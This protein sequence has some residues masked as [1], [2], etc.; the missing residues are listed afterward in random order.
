MAQPCTRAVARTNGR[1]PIAEGTPD[2]RDLTPWLRGLGV[3]ASEARR[4]AEI[5]ETT[6]PDASLEERVKRA[7][8]YL[9]P[10]QCR[11]AAP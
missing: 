11:V 6:M 3:G 1:A 10:R 5:C 4:M 9:A 2:D 7:L 8:S